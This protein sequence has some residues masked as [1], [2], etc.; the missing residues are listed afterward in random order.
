MPKSGNSR[1]FFPSKTKIYNFTAYELAS[2]KTI[3][4]VL[5]HS[6]YLVHPDLKRQIFINFYIS[7]EFEYDAMIYYLKRN[8][9]IGEYRIK[10]V[11]EPIL[12]LSQ[13]FNPAET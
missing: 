3:Q 13:L 12:F 10:K 11:V 2:F 1:R 7:K 5:S 6:L 9:A 8:L 4:N